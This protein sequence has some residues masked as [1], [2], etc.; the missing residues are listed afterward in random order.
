MFEDGEPEQIPELEPCVMIPYM[1]I[2]LK[3]D[4]NNQVVQTIP[5][6][7]S[8]ENF[9]THFYELTVK[10]IVENSV[11]R[12]WEKLEDFWE[13]YSM[14]FPMINTF[15]YS[16]YFFTNQE[17]YAFSYNEDD[18]FKLYTIYYNDFHYPALN[19]T[20]SVFLEYDEIN[21]DE[22]NDDDANSDDTVHDHS[23]E[24]LEELEELEI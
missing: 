14:Q 17:W 20:N 23:V 16:I 13:F 22:N 11:H 4:T 21:E 6:V 9:I 15:P 1:V 7:I 19:M 24:E 10:F 2:F 12:K 3:Q 8:Q 5:G 18:L